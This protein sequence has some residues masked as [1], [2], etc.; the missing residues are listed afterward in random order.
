[1]KLISQTDKTVQY[2]SVN[3][4]CRRYPM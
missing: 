4:E 3:Y 2:L 1:M